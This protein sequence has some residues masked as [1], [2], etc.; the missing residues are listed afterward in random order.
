[1]YMLKI[2]CP[3]NPKMVIV[4]IPRLILFFLVLL[5]ITSLF[6][7]LPLGAIASAFLIG[8]F[9]PIALCQPISTLPTKG[10]R[11]CASLLMILCYPILCSLT[12]LMLVMMIFLYP[13]LRNKN[14]HG[15]YDPFD[16][17]MSFLAIKYLQFATWL[18][19][20][21]AD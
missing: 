1:M 7:L 3:T 19:Y 6:I 13:F 21:C 9:I 18:L 17:G 4:L 16:N 20:C 12:V 5:P 2:K 15:A 10:A 14:H 8:L 11:L